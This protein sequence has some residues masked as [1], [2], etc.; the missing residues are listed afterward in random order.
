MRK[1]ILIVLTSCF[2]FQSCDKDDEPNSVLVNFTFENEESLSQ[3]ESEN[4]TIVLDN[5]NSVSG[6]SSAKINCT[7]GCTPFG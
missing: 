1:I 5:T 3:W 4:G 7:I 6:T 2:L